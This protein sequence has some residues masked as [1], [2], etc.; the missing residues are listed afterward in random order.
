MAIDRGMYSTD[1]SFRY[2]GDGLAR[3]FRE[4]APLSYDD[5][6]KIAHANAERLLK[7]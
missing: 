3:A 5:K 2:N 4:Q 7:L 6:V 1:Y